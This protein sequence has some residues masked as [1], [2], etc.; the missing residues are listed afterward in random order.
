[1]KTLVLTEVE[2]LVPLLANDALWRNKTC[3]SGRQPADRVTNIIIII[4][5]LYLSLPHPTRSVA[6]DTQHYKSVVIIN[7]KANINSMS[8]LKGKRSCHGSLNSTHGWDI[9]IGLLLATMTM[10]PDCRG[11]MYSVSKFF[12]QS[13]APGE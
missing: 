5:S 7:N 4:I 2:R 6:P 11:E 3:C 13:C 12:D 10:S 1:M 8:D 9:P